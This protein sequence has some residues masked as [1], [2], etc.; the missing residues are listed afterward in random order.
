MNHQWT[1]LNVNPLKFLPQK[2][3]NQFVCSC[4]N[5]LWTIFKHHC[6]CMH[7]VPFTFLWCP[8][9]S[10]LRA[11]FEPA[12]LSLHTT[13]HVRRKTN[14]RTAKMARYR[15][16]YQLPV[17][18]ISFS[19]PTCLLVSAKTRRTENSQLIALLYNHIREGD[20]LKWGETNIT[21]IITFIFGRED[22]KF[23]ERFIPQLPHYWGIVANMFVWNDAIVHT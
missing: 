19:E 11:F 2:F 9:R 17:K 1:T 18:A 21:A 4:S 14:N 7:C 20:N 10:N 3:K 16:G 12:S 22:I 5:L 13:P 15:A 8:G 6:F 23:A